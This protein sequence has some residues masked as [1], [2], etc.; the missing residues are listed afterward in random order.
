MSKLDSKPAPGISDI[1]TAI[2][3]HIW[4]IASTMLASIFNSCIDTGQFCLEWAAKILPLYKNKGDRHKVNSYRSIAILPQV[5]KV[6]ER[7]L[8]RQL[9]KYFNDSSLFSSSQHGF[10]KGHLS[11]TALHELLSS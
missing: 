8:V 3:K 6:F 11:E 9:T 5:R 1:Q 7:I 10:R 2:L 4:P